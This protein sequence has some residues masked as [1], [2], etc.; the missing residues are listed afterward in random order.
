MGR[1][2]GGGGGHKGKRGGSKRGR[3]R[4]PGGYARKDGND[5]YKE[6]VRENETMINYY[7]VCT[8]PA[9]P[10]TSGKAAAKNRRGGSKLGGLGVSGVPPPPAC[11]PDWATTGLKCCPGSRCLTAPSP[12]RC[13][14]S[15]GISVRGG[16]GR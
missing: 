14:Y 9:C 3:D 12:H 15:R 16:S 5:G 13:L 11:A 10:H 1:R 4:E 8:L 7:K 6:I 2:G